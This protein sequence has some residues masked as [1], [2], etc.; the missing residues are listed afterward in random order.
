MIQPVNSFVE[1]E[2]ILF[3]SSL[4]EIPVAQATK[5]AKISNLLRSEYPVFVGNFLA[6]VSVG[7]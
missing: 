7:W 4:G 5:A 3:K 6:L 1:F 2:P